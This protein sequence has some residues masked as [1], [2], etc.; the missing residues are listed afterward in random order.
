M[1]TIKVKAPAKINLTLEVMKQ[2]KDGFHEIQ[3]IM[4]AISLYD[5]ITIQVSPSDKNEITLSGTSTEI[6]YN[7]KNLAYKA[8]DLFLGQIEG[9]FKVHIHIEKNIPIEAGL[10]GGSA[11][12][13]GVFYGLNKIFNN[14]FSSE[15]LLDLCSQIGSD[16]SFCMFG[17]TQLATSRGEVLK[18]VDTPEIKVL[19]IKPKTFGIS[20]KEAYRK[21]DKLKEKSKLN[22]TFNMLMAINKSED[23][24][25]FLAN[26]L[27]RAIDKDY[28]QIRQLKNYI[29]S[30]GCKNALMSGSGSTVFG[31]LEHDI[32]LPEGLNAECFLA[33]SINHGVRVV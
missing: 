21:F 32:E 11:D 26:D 6:P 7:E 17:G 14:V 10:A 1:K 25:P 4:Q 9:T 8:C 20:A 30:L 29:M 24:T 19:L 3:S 18:K 15:E 28:P 16:I 31:L 12:A 33:E 5:Y 22:A 23:I 27:E 13:A 2:R